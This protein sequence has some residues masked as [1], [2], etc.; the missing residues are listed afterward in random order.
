M[1]LD[2]VFGVLIHRKVHPRKEKVVCE[3]GLDEAD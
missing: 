3:V 2:L 1:L